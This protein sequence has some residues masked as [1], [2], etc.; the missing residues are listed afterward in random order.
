MLSAGD[1]KVKRQCGLY[2][3]FRVKA[4]IK[5]IEYKVRVL[6]YVCVR[7][8]ECANNNNNN[9]YL[10]SI[11][12]VQGTVTFICTVSNNSPCHPLNSRIGL[13]PHFTNKKSDRFREVS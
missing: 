3:S 9:V 13:L 4:N 5:Q 12:S 2:F 1:V 7:V 6:E 8:C 11:Y 10:L